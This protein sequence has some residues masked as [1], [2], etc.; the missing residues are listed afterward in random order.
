MGGIL[1]LK[2]D[3]ITPTRPPPLINQI[4]LNLLLRILRLPPQY[5]ENNEAL[6]RG[7]C[8]FA[9]GAAGFTCVGVFSAGA[10]GPF[11]LHVLFEGEG[12]HLI[13]LPHF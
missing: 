5:V 10:L 7:A 3:I 1:K 2:V 4:P 8:L 12:G 11:D 9:V 13:N 6:C